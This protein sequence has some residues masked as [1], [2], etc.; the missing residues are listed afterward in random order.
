MKRIKGKDNLNTIEEWNVYYGCVDRSELK[1]NRFYIYKGI[2]KFLKKKECSLLEIGCGEGFGLDL[3]SQNFPNFKLTGYDFSP[4]AIELAKKN[5]NH[6]NFKVHDILKDKIENVYDYIICLETL[7][8]LEKPNFVIDKCLQK[9]KKFILS[10]PYREYMKK[11][12]LHIITDIT[13][14]SF[15]KYAILESGFL[16]KKIIQIVLKGRV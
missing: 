1:A 16:D 3:I 4:T 6:I 13:L 8:H 12:S 2:L 11:D 5:F 14:K 7:E 10:C 9:C 15:N